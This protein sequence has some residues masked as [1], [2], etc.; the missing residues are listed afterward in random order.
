MLRTLLPRGRQSGEGDEASD[1]CPSRRPPRAALGR[2][3]MPAPVLSPTPE[4]F[5]FTERVAKRDPV[6]SVHRDALTLRPGTAGS[7]GFRAMEPSG[8]PEG[9]PRLHLGF[10]QVL[11]TC[12]CACQA[13]VHER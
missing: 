4:R 9:T 5:G 2:G 10:L 1:E 13:R 7:G 11:T 6:G 8:S 3:R 12:A